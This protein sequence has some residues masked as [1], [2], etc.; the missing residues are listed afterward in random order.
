MHQRQ[1]MSLLRSYMSQDRD[2]LAGAPQTKGSAG[3]EQSAAPS[4]CLFP[5]LQK[6][7][8]FSCFGK[9]PFLSYPLQTA[10]RE[11]N[12][13]EQKMNI[14]ISIKAKLIATE[15]KSNLLVA[16]PWCVRHIRYTGILS[17]EN[18]RLDMFFQ[19]GRSSSSCFA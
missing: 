16:V 7:P 19:V 8:C 4:L 17:V 13:A 12:I 6:E 15:V 11:K 10:L 14:Y 1:H 5:R 2:P 3:K 9:Y 18:G